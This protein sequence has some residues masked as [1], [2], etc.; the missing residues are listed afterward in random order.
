[1]P[2]SSLFSRIS[3]VICTRDRQGSI[4]GA[5]DSV[6][7]DHPDFEV[8]VIDQ[9]CSDETARAVDRNRRLYQPPAVSAATIAEHA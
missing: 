8:L 3:V 2:E 9:S 4:G 6:A 5:L 7:Q 1:M